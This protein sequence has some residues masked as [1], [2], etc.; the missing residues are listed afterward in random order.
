MFILTSSTVRENAASSGPDGSSDASRDSAAPLCQ[1]SLSLSSHARYFDTLPFPPHKSGIL[2]GT[3]RASAERLS[4]KS[5]YRTHVKLIKRVEIQQAAERVSQALKAHSIAMPYGPT[6][7]SIM[8]S[9]NGEG[10]LR[11]SLG[12]TSFCLD[13]MSQGLGGTPNV[14]P[15][16]HQGGTQ[17]WSYN[18]ESQTIKSS[19]P[20][21]G[22]IGATADG[23][24]K[25]VD[26]DSQPFELRSWDWKSSG[27]LI[28]RSD[29][30]LKMTFP[31]SAP[32]SLCLAVN[33]QN[34]NKKH[35]VLKPCAA[36]FSS[37]SP[38]DATRDGCWSS[39]A[40]NLTV[41]LVASMTLTRWSRL[42]SAPR[43]SVPDIRAPGCKGYINTV[44]KDYGLTANVGSTISSMFRHA[45]TLV[46]RLEPTSIIIC[47]VDEEWWA[48][49]RTLHS[50]L[51]RS[52]AVLIHEIILLDDGSE[53]PHLGLPLEAYVSALPSRPKVSIVR[54]HKRLGLIKARLPGC[55]EGV[56]RCAHIFR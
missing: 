9:H 41:Q 54:T 40:C 49:L 30:D 22:C 34:N 45:E 25:L 32:R 51:D 16:H 43:R 10:E 12:G 13:T 24:I 56:I 42:Q 17:S 50:V 53:A 27:Q 35:L 14:F 28:I 29:I 20:G 5:S 15:C 23:A 48:L 31:V 21:V 52:P 11:I 4:G 33:L 2:G 46:K 47:F 26:C 6:L 19:R 3:A 18:I 37:K 55:C 7:E 8:S 44:H 1:S 39:R 38:Y 36:Y